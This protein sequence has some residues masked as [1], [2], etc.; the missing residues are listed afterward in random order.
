MD[1][2]EAEDVNDPFSNL[3]DRCVIPFGVRGKV[4]YKTVERRRGDMQRAQ[5]ISS[6]FLRC[7]FKRLDHVSEVSLITIV[8]PIGDEENRA[9]AT[10]ARG[11][12]SALDRGE[13]RKACPNI[14]VTVHDTVVRREMR[15]S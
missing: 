2:N 13:D 1:R 10:I 7:P 12:S 11:N 5:F 14:G 8:I 15:I 6:W 4:N 3:E 9:T